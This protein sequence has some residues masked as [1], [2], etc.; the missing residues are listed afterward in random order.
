MRNRKS[1]WKLG[2]TAALLIGVIIAGAMTA[3]VN[4]LGY[5]TVVQWPTGQK[6]V[7]FEP[8]IY[9]KAFG[10]NWT[11]PDVITMDYDKLQTTDVDATLSQMGV[12][13]RYQDGGLGTIYGQDRYSLPTD[14]ET[15]LELHRAFRSKDGVANKL[16]RPVTEEAINMTAGL[17]SSEASYAELRGTFIQ[18]SKDQIKN[19]K[20]E[21]FLERKQVENEQGKVVWKSVPVIR[22]DAETGQ[23]VHQQSD[24]EKY[25]IKLSGHQ[26][27]EWDFEEKT[28]KQ[29]SDKREA[30]MAII[31]AKANAERAKQ[32]AITTEQQGL[33]NVV[34]AKYEQEVLKESAVVQAEREKEV[35]VINAERRVDVAEQAKLEAEQKKL[36]AV[37]YKQEQILRGE[38]DS[39][40]KRLVIQADGALEQKLA[41]YVEVQANYAREFGKQKW[42]PEVM[43]GNANASGTSGSAAQ[44]LMD[45]LSIKAAK[46]LSLDM[47]MDPG[48]SQ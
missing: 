31:T 18:W 8:G 33:A 48:F 10:N 1:Y 24:L 45:L 23:P 29:I 21:T 35:A 7:K 30:S 36:Q 6:F 37:E 11:Y 39:E 4:E 2:I 34:K 42:V 5:R 3:G 46:D 32:D 15:M 9:I 47:K 16:I 20:Y 12:D 41:A 43:M 22:F 26:I 40:R 17:M 14:E 13:V 25:G 19:G 28:L 38:G 44:D 27:T